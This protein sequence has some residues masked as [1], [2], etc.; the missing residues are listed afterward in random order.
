VGA[1]LRRIA[2]A[3]VACGVGLS[4]F[5]VPL[6]VAIAGDHRPKTSTPLVTHLGF[7]PIRRGSSAAA[8]YL[9]AG[10]FELSSLASPAWRSSSVEAGTG[11]T[12]SGQAAAS[13]YRPESVSVLPGVTPPGSLTP[14]DTIDAAGPTTIV[15]VTN[16]RL[17]MR[18][19]LGGRSSTNLQTMFGGG[20]RVSDPQ[21]IWD[22]TTQHFYFVVLDVQVRPFGAPNGVDFWYGFSKTDS[23]AAAGD[24]CFYPVSLGYDNAPTS[25]K[26]GDQPH[27]GDSEGYVFWGSNVFDGNHPNFFSPDVAWVQ[28]PP[29]GDIVSCPGTLND[30][31]RK[32]IQS[33][34]DT[35]TAVYTPV[36]VNQTDGG[37]TGYVVSL[38]VPR[39]TS[40]A[41]QLG[42]ITV[43]DG[44]SAPTISATAT[45]VAV[46]PYSRP[47]PARQ[48]GT[49]ARIDTN[50]GRLT[51]AV[52]AVDPSNGGH[53]GIW[54]QHAVSTGSGPSAVRWYEIDPTSP[55][56]PF[57][58]GTIR[59][60]RLSV[61]NAAISPD[62]VVNGSDP[63]VFGDAMAMTFTTSSTLTDSTLWSVSKVGDLPVSPWVLIKQS[64]KPEIDL[65]CSPG[66]CR[67]GDFASAS[68]DPGADVA[69]T[70]GVVWFSSE[71]NVRSRSNSDV[72]WRS[73]DWNV[74][75]LP[76]ASPCE[77]IGTTNDDRLV[78]DR[79][80][81]LCGG[82]GDDTL[83]GGRGV[84][85]LN[86]GRGS[87]RLVGSRGDDDLFGGRGPDDLAGGSG[88]DYLNGGPGSDHCAG[89]AGRDRLVS[90]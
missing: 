18:N 41:D 5:G 84:D 36:G 16:E 3:G 58:R 73:L 81:E 40:V 38:V 87:D 45:S 19:R 70:H 28:K 7:G 2:T 77:Q 61:F 57:R 47:P 79:G 33:D 67:W 39:S 69:G 10:R 12:P 26:F 17:S 9:A 65:T 30:G 31:V 37:P 82:T 24:W 4:L 83:F 56:A 6:R 85:T 43:A 89:G 74:A 63:P 75:L 25:T 23:P 64:T 11:T 80:Q 21:V 34:D 59:N 53:V 29:A 86:G 20:A 42:V 14:P 55:S 35:N 78:S 52:S 51:Q 62:R 90:C 68:P 32:N 54:T 71:W 60:R 1:R 76:S 66:P 27:L 15:A 22:P 49:S 72:E 88:D 50:D 46:A 44:P 8:A 13:Q 48:R